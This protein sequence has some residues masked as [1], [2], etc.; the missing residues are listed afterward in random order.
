MMFVYALAIYVSPIHSYCA[1]YINST[2][3]DLMQSLTATD[4]LP[5]PGH[6]KLQFEL[7]CIF[8]ILLK[9]R[10]NIFYRDLPFEV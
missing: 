3:E 2:D 1:H 8:E 6:V 10:E 5:G 4:E 9:F 7:L